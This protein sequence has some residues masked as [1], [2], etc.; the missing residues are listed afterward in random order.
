MSKLLRLIA[1]A[2]AL[3]LAA[4]PIIMWLHERWA[5][6]GPTVDHTTKLGIVDEREA[7]DGWLRSTGYSPLLPWQS[8][9]YEQGRAGMLVHDPRK[10]VKVPHA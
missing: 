4:M 6:Q 8:S 3:S 10:I 5:S 7:I 2:F 9:F 1:T